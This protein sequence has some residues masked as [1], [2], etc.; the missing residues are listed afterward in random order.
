MDQRHGEV[1]VCEKANGNGHLR[2]SGAPSRGQA[3]MMRSGVEGQVVDEALRAQSCLV[4]G[5]VSYSQARGQQQESGQH[6][7]RT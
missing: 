6:G 4:G 5:G 3:G 7:Q 1:P 2:K